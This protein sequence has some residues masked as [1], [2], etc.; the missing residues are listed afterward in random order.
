MSALASLIVTVA[1][2][3]EEISDWLRLNRKHSFHTVLGSRLLV[4]I[5]HTQTTDPAVGITGRIAAIFHP[6]PMGKFLFRAGVGSSLTTHTFTNT[7]VG[8]VR[9]RNNFSGRL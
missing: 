5:G 1:T 6:S 8:T 3:K 2:E 4:I 9:E 7:C